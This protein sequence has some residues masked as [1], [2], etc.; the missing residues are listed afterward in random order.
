MNP[1]PNFSN[2]ATVGGANL[3]LRYEMAGKYIPY[4]PRRQIGDWRA[5]WF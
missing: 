5:E 4:T 1:Y 3:E 2:I